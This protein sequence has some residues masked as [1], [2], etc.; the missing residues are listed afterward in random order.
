M[1]PAETI[2]TLR[3]RPVRR[4][5]IACAGRSPLLSPE[6]PS[7]LPIGRE[8][9]IGRTA[10]S[11]QA[12]YSVPTCS[13]LIGMRFSMSKLRMAIRRATLSASQRSPPPISPTSSSKS[14]VAA[15]G[16][17]TVVTCSSEAILL[18]LLS[19]RVTRRAPIGAIETDAN[20][21]A[22]PRPVARTAWQP[23][24]TCF[25]LGIRMNEPEMA[26]LIVTYGPPGFYFR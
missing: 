3:R 5:P 6:R 23:R 4:A 1:R 9:E 7:C 14:V 11:P 20:C 15:G 10:G 18:P 21:L 2:S 25:R 17:P 26:A 16:A 13:R 24:V 19:G 22:F 12:M 8:G